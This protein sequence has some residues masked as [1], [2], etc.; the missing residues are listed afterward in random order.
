MS[1][2][3]AIFDLPRLAESVRP[4]RLHYF[5]SVASTN[6]HAAAMRRA[7]ELFAPA[8][9]L[10][11]QQLAGRGRGANRWFSNTGSLTITYCLP[12]HEQLA[13]QQ[14]PLVAG[15]AVRNA[16]TELTGDTNIAIK[17]PND[18]FHDSRKIAGLLCER[19]QGID[20]V[21]IGLNVNLLP[22][23]LPPE[24]RQ[25]TASLALL[26]GQTFDLTQVA[27][28]L[29]QHLS[30]T[31]QTWGSHPFATFVDLF[32]QHDALLGRSISVTVAGENLPIKGTCEGIDS[33]GRLLVRSPRALHS[34]VA[35]SVSL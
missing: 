13:P 1:T 23:D 32:R 14:L 8:I 7:G 28:I 30:H 33:E 25:T 16:A 27:I 35:G 6:D 9:I 11:E 3:P 10:A 20:L 2:A 21:G 17:W 34:I 22:A 18:V 24:L 31:L 12:I 5:P 19:L 29:T 15:L 4:F 26:A